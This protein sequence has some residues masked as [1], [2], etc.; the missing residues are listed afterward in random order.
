MIPLKQPELATLV[1]ELEEQI[2]IL[3]T[4]KRA[5]EERVKE[6][7]QQRKIGSHHAEYILSGEL[8]PPDEA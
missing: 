3:G 5:I 7:Q 6:L 4:Q 8:K 2:S 1:N